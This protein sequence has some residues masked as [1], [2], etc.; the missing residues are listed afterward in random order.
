M[1]YLAHLYF[2]SD[3][4][5]SMVGNLLPDFT[6]TLSHETY[7]PEVLKGIALHR[8]IDHYTDQHPIVKESKTRISKE[9]RRFSAILIDIFYD[10]FL[11]KHWE[12]Y[13]KSTL[14]ESTH[15]YYQQLPLSTALL[16]KRLEEAIVRMPQIDLLYNYQ[17]LKGMEHAV[18]RLSQRIRFENNLHGG[19]VELEEN[20]LELEEDFHH[21]FKA[22]QIAVDIYKSPSLESLS[23]SS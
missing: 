7:S 10:H 21:Y 14:R 15:C 12:Q 23:Q 1:N 17:S 6:K 19:I 20:Y 2:A 18:N 11:A 16:P 4:P 13:A 3:S 9:R 5:D 8:F 22:L